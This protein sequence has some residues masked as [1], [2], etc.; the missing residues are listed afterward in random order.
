MKKPTKKYRWRNSATGCFTS[1]EYAE[2][3]PET[4]QRCAVRPRCDRAKTA[5][6]TRNG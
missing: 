5:E 6:Q 2:A 4:T 1:R 3:N